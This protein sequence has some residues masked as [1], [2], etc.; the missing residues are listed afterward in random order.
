LR[1]RF[2]LDF[3]SFVQKLERS[4][5]LGSAREMAGKRS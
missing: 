3:P 4:A 1:A 5:K 2:G